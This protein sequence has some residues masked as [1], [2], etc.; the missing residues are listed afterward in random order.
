MHVLQFLPLAKWIIA[1]TRTS[2]QITGVIELYK[3]C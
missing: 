1:Q 2:Q 3:L